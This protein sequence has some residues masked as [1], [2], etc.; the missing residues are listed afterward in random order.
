MFRVIFLGF[1]VFTM[2]CVLVPTATYAMSLDDDEEDREDAE[3]YLAEAKKAGASESFGTADALLRKAKQLG[4]LEDDV[5]KAQKYVAGKKEAK[6][7]RERKE[8]ERLAKL[9]REKEQRARQARLAQQR[10][11]TASSQSRYITSLGSNAPSYQYDKY[12]VW[13]RPYMSISDGTHIYAKVTKRYSGD[14]YSLL[15]GSNDSNIYGNCSNCSNSLNSYWSCHANGGSSFT[16]SGNQAEAAN[17][18][19]QR[20]N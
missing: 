1:L 4:V 15:V 16:V 18:I 6:A 14:C 20:S 13:Y 3:D 2:S 11:Q 10:Q 9:K 5:S 8:R 17:A 7:L 12:T 19:V